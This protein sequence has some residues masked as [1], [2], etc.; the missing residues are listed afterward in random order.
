VTPDAEDW[1]ARHDLDELIANY[2]GVAFAAFAS[3][4]QIA[5]AL[6]CSI[7]EAQAFQFSAQDDL[8]IMK[9]EARNRRRAAGP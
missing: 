4:T 7:D 6:G 9:I 8:A 5:A 2:R 1:R 3:T